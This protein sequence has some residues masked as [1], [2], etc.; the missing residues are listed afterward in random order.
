MRKEKKQFQHELNIIFH[1]HQLTSA[2]K[3]KML[4]KAKSVSSSSVRTVPIVK[5]ALIT[6]MTAI[7][8]T[9]FIVI[10]GFYLF[11]GFRNNDVEEYT[12]EVQ[13]SENSASDIE[14]QQQSIKTFLTNEDPSAIGVFGLNDHA[15]FT[16]LE[17]NPF[18]PIQQIVPTLTS[19]SSELRFIMTTEEMKQISDRHDA[20]QTI[21]PVGIYERGIFLQ[22][23]CAV[24]LLEVDGVDLQT[25]VH[26]IG[27]QFPKVPVTVA[28]FTAPKDGKERILEQQVIGYRYGEYQQLQDIR[29]TGFSFQQELGTRIS[30]NIDVVD[31]TIQMENTENWVRHHKAVSVDGYFSK[32][33][34]DTSVV[35]S[36][37]NQKLVVGTIQISADKDYTKEEQEEIIE[38]ALLEVETYYQTSNQ[39]IKVYFHND[40]YYENNRS[41][42]IAI[43]FPDLEKPFYS[44][45]EER[46]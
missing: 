41:Q 13:L 39:S 37:P 20:I 14:H 24:H 34:W 5:R 27:N 28:F 43:K 29:H 44:Y 9:S 38:K 26:D 18:G 32:E 7:I 40:M 12:N 16:S 35:P 10:L 33:N 23:A 2:K 30:Q 36:S 1:Q 11:E 15:K 25:I 45:I 42:T 17:D 3:M 31:A 8:Y 19:V 21:I 22:V 46:W 6:I 4:E